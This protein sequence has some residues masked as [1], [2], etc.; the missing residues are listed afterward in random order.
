MELLLHAI[1]GICWH[2]IPKDK[3]QP[4]HASSIQKLSRLCRWPLDAFRTVIG[5]TKEAV[6][7]NKTASNVKELGQGPKNLEGK[8]KKAL[9]V[10]EDGRYDWSAWIQL[11]CQWV[12]AV[13][14]ATGPHFSLPN[15]WHMSTSSFQVKKKYLSCH[16]FLPV[17]SNNLNLHHASC[18]SSIV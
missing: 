6:E 11:A 16:N 17:T 9:I 12:S 4:T 8:E 7:E 14:L 3:K 1:T 18:Y 5:N 13:D 15:F 2:I 10:S